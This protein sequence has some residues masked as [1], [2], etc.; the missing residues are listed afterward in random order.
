MKTVNSSAR[1]QFP[2]LLSCANQ[3]FC[4]RTCDL[5]LQMG[6]AVG[7]S[8]TQLLQEC[9]NPSSSTFYV[10]IQM[11]MARPERFLNGRRLT[12]SAKNREGASGSGDF[13]CKRSTTEKLRHR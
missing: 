4:N 1:T 13:G 11:S 5:E 6:I 9:L 8:D 3:C 2:P 7:L 12:P 10:A